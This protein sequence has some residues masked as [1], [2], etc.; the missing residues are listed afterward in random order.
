VLFDEQNMAVLEDM[1]SAARGSESHA[2]AGDLNNACLSYV[3]VS[4]GQHAVT[5]L[6]GTMS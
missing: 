6:E 3:L 4:C 1:V 2:H 5:M